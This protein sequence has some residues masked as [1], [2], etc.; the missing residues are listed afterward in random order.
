MSPF[1]VFIFGFSVRETLN[2]TQI[3]SPA[4]SRYG[5][6]TADEKARLL[7]DLKILSQAPTAGARPAL[8]PHIAAAFAPEA[9]VTIPQK[10]FVLTGEFVF[11]SRPTCERAILKR[12]GS[13]G[14][15]VSG[16]TDY[17]VVGDLTTPAWLD[18]NFSRKIQ[19]AVD[20]AKSGAAR[21]SVVRESDWAAALN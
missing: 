8:P 20:L 3:S 7:E 14:S 18:Q 12:G 17:L 16:R 21:I 6:L 19:H 4:S 15:S 9:V 1:L 13:L 5:I 11:G 2:R 10:I